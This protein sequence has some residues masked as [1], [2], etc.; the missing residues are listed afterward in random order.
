VYLCGGTFV[1]KMFH[2]QPRQRA[3][4]VVS[5]LFSG[6][7]GPLEGHRISLYP[8]REYKPPFF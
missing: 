7:N 3:Q 4:G 2:P 8:L 1:E 6:T 5:A